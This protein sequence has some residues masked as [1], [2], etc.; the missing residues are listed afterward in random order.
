MG[1][2]GWVCVGLVLVRG[3]AVAGSAGL[4]GGVA[5]F[6]VPGASAGVVGGLEGR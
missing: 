6:F 4:L 5:C 3:I 1:M 2:G